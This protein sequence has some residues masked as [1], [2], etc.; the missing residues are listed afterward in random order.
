MNDLE[1]QIKNRREEFDNS[2]P[3]EGHFE[4]FREKLDLKP[5]RNFLFS[6]RIAAAILAGA[7]IIGISI[8]S[9]GLSNTESKFYASFDQELKETVYFYSTMNAEMEKEINELNFSTE[10]EK[11]EILRDIKS[12]DKNINKIKEDL[13]MFPSDERVRNALIEHHRNKTELLEFIIS[14]I[15]INKI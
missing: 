7:I 5:K 12:Y 3:P 13:I 6:L 1:K 14:Q 9:M 11:H 8:Y 2:L 10:T 4:R 15:E